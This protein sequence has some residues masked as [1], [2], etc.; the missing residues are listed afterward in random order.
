M[1]AS[2]TACQACGAC[3][4]YSPTWPR[5]STEDDIDLAR[6]PLALVDDGLAGMR[7]DRN[8]C[9]A[10]G[11]TVGV[12]TW[13]AIYSIRPEVCRACQ[14]GDE[15]CTMARRHHGLPPLSG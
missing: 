14:P 13:C 8:R 7:C 15:A 1:T 12:R 10:L 11:G 9:L 5:F 2:G 3:C 6:I 4:D